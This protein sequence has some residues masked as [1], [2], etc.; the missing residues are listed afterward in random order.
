MYRYCYCSSDGDK[1]L[2]QMALRKMKRSCLFDIWNGQ[3]ADQKP[4][5]RSIIRSEADSFILGTRPFFYFTFYGNEMPIRMEGRT[6][7]NFLRGFWK[8]TLVVFTKNALTDGPNA[9]FRKDYGKRRL[10]F[11]KNV[12]TDGPNATLETVFLIIA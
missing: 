3:V 10:L 9:T 8:K 11:C 7:F 12:S 2:M 6:K 4:K 1:R 5:E